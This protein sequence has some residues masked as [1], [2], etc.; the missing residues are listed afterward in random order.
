[1]SADGH[2]VFVAV[3]LDPALYGAVVALERR[4]EQ[5]GARLRWVPPEN[6]HFTLRF[7][8]HISDAQL[9]AARQ[10]VR[11]GCAGVRRFRIV[12]SGVGAFPSLSRPQV[13]WVGVSDGAGELVDL[14]RRV[15]E[16]LS[17]H[18][19]PKDPRG[20]SAHLTLARVKESALWGA[21]SRALAA[22][23][24]A[25]VGTQEVT[26]VRVVESLLRPQGPLYTPVEEVPLSPYEK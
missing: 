3:A 14:A 26:S 12:V 6:L 10:A 17:R 22:L 1:M 23:E 7:L 20:F 16:A 8:G 11:E 15:E 21:T 5:A 4:L 19:F 24:G 9:E 2:R 25:V 13:V 18:R